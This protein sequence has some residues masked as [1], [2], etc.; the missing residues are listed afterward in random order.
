[1][2]NFVALYGK[3]VIF[4]VLGAVLGTLGSMLVTIIYSKRKD[5]AF[6]NNVYTLIGSEVPAIQDLEII[7][8]KHNVE[9]LASGYL[10]YWNNGKDSIRAEDVAD[11]IS[12]SLSEGSVFYYAEVIE[13]TSKANNFDVTL[14]DDG[15][16]IILSF[17]YLNYQ[18][19]AVIYYVSNETDYTHY[20][21]ESNVIDSKP[22]Y[23]NYLSEDKMKTRIAIIVRFLRDIL[24][25]VLVGITLCGIWRRVDQYFL[26]ISFL[27]IALSML[28]IWLNYSL[29]F[30]EVF[31]KMPK[32]FH[33]YF[34]KF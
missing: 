4:L 11:Q 26:V 5:P 17:K 3:E 6:F 2:E 27:V 34:K 16:K 8:K 21:M 20:E 23:N 14:S 12:F 10:A 7:Y 32:Q 22:M 13:R 33:K 28:F 25:G 19:G 31:S 18:D 9:K 1:M 30:G 15:R 24:L 29:R